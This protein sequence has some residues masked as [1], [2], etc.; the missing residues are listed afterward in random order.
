LTRSQRRAYI[1][2]VVPAAEEIP[3]W[4]EECGYTLVERVGAAAGTVDRVACA[5]GAGEG[6]G[7]WW[8]TAERFPRDLPASLRELEAGRVARGAGRAWVIVTGEATPE[9]V[10][11]DLD[12]SPAAYVSARQVALHLAGVVD[13]LRELAAKERDPFYLPRRGTIGGVA[14]EDLGAAIDAWIEGGAEWALHA[15][16]EVRIRPTLDEVMRVRATRA[17]RDGVDRSIA[18]VGSFRPRGWEF[19]RDPYP[20]TLFDR[21]DVQGWRA[22]VG[23][24]DPDLDVRV[25]RAGEPASADGGTAVVALAP[26][27]AEGLRR[28]FDVTLPRPTAVRAAELLER[29]PALRALLDWPLNQRAMIDAARA[30]PPTDLDEL[31]RRQCVVAL[32]E[33]AAAAGLRDPVVHQERM[34]QFMEQVAFRVFSFGGSIAQPIDGVLDGAL[35][36]GW[37]ALEPGSPPRRWMSLDAS[38]AHYQFTS[39]LVRDWLIARCVAREV[40]EGRDEVLTRHVFPRVHVLDF[41]SVLAPDVTAR[42]MDD[43]LTELRGEI[44]AQVTRDVQLTLGHQLNRSVGAIRA[45][46]KTA[47]RALEAAP[48]DDNTSIALARIEEELAH[49]ARLSDR[50]RLLLDL[51][52]EPLQTID[53]AEV[54]R[55]AIEPLSALHRDVALDVEVAAALRVRAHREGAREI[56]HCLVENALHS[57]AL[58]AAERPGRVLVTAARDGET[59][60]L[61]V[62]DNGVGV[63]S[64]DRERIFEAFVTTKKGGPTPRGTGLGLPIARRYARQMGARVELEASNGETVFA[65]VFVAGGEHE[66]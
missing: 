20:R 29:V 43:R 39:S 34:L 19:P 56:V 10:V 26:L 65:A 17:L 63:R 52:E 57:V 64:G 59:V 11:V 54:V 33:R 1:V 13:A 37:L 28:W 18:F 27:A 16:E 49:L 2:A 12:A 55:A 32:F 58:T 38:K 30:V 31:W 50:S 8:R 5:R 23:R 46:L 61:T 3:Q 44:E 22:R 9:G 60:R 41:L 66:R 62:R 6:E 48:L 14:H 24:L 35:A 42:L 25:P 21:I 53:L 4:F 45:N 51:R 15:D 36:L 40:R 47:R 7:V